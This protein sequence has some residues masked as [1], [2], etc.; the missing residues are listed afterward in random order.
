MRVQGVRDEMWLVSCGFE[1]AGT[2][3]SSPEAVLR[4][5]AQGMR[6][7]CTDQRD[8]D[9]TAPEVLLGDAAVASG[10][11]IWAC[12]RY[13]RCRSRSCA[14]RSRAVVLCCPAARSHASAA[15]G[16]EAVWTLSREGP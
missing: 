2:S 10:R 1:P 15:G 16:S 5:H 12:V 11:A 6:T 7:H 9:G 4:V 13:S 3:M 14:L 8:L